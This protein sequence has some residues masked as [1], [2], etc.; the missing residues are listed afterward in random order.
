MR[1][2]LALAG[3]VM[4]GQWLAFAGNPSPAD[5]SRA[6]LAATARHDYAEAARVWSRAASLQ[7][8]NPTFHYRLASALARLGHRRSA[9]DAFHVALLLEPPEPLAKLAREGLAELVSE[10]PPSDVETS[11]PVEA[12]RGVW[13]AVVTLNDVHRGR[14]LVDTGASLT[15]VSPALAR[16]AGIGERHGAPT[17]ELQTVGGRAAGRSTRIHSIRLGEAEARDVEALIVDPGPGLDG[18][19]GNT[20]L[21]RY[22]VTLDADASTLG[23]RPLG[24][25]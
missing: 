15:L 25:P 24:K 10:T 13:I 7:P 3:G 5:L 17:L 20:F 12:A 11:V 6:G 1:R 9:A 21:G 23:L 16:A 4:I 2:W 8:Y 22:V 19:L 18:I 14:F